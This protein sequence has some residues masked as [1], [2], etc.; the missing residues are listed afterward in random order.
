MKR[1]IAL[2]L[3]TAGPASGE[4][5]IQASDARVDVIENGNAVTSLHFSTT[6]YLYPLPS[7]SGANLAR[8][9]PM[10]KGVKGEQK[11]HPHHRSL[12]FSHGSVDGFDFWSWQGKGKPEIKY[13]GS[14]KTQTTE[15]SASFTV[16]LDWIAEQ[17]TLLHEVRSY[18]FSRPNPETLAIEITCRLSPADQP[19]LFGDTKEGTLALRVDRSLRQKGPSAKGHILDSEGRRDAACWGKR[20]KWVAFHGPDELNQP[21]VLAILDHPD[22]LRHP[23]WWHARNYGLLAANPFG[24][25]DFEK[26][27]DKTIGDYL[28]KK[29]ETL[30]FRYLVILHHGS[31][32]SAT[33]DEHWKQFAQ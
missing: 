28:L 25:H 26:K 20:S 4:W 27:S 14:T 21:A 16:T 19:V 8:H 15:D 18:Q 2:I 32:K 6:P 9:W 7:A 10:E 33:L 1:I 29:G 22:N 17:R 5:K 30:E 11:D 13:T 23:C 31:P 3:A 24:I 12:W